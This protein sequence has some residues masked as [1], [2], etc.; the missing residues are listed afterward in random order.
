MTR[1]RLLVLGLLICWPAASQGEVLTFAFE[2]NVTNVND[3]I[4]ILDFVQPGDRFVYTF[5]FNTD[6]PNIYPYPHPS[7]AAYEGISSSLSVADFC[8]ASGTPFMLI[9]D[10]PQSDSFEVQ[11]GIEWDHP[12]LLPGNRAVSVRLTWGDVFDSPSL[13]HYPYDL[14]LFTYAGF[15]VQFTAPG[16]STGVLFGFGGDVDSMYI[17]PEPSTAML[18]VLAALAI[19]GRWA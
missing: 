18:L 8:F 2:G 17:V 1:A 19:R 9:A 14:A 15:Y 16:G 10:L 3:P 7:A 4:G 5:S 6:A 11:S 12:Q 13:P